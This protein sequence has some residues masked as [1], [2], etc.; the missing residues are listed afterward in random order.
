MNAHSLFWSNSVHRKTFHV[1]LTSLRG[2]FL[3][4]ESDWLVSHSKNHISPYQLVIETKWRTYSNYA[5]HAPN[6]TLP[7]LLGPAI[8]LH[9]AI[10]KESNTLSRIFTLWKRTIES[11]FP[12]SFHFVLASLRSS[13]FNWVL[14]ILK[15]TSRY[16]DLL[17]VTN[18]IW[19][20]RSH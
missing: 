18:G 11:D 14:K 10:K 2:L 7:V 5:Y 8:I 9:K 17:P 20:V 16:V 13:R 12:D 6:R 19:I 1:Q 3:S 4:S 15:R